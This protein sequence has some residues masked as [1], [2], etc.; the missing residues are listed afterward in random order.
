MLSVAKEKLKTKTIEWQEIDAQELPFA[1]NSIDLVVCC[2]G[3]MFVPD[4]LKAYKEAYRVL[5][6]GGMLLFTSWDKLEENYVSHVYRTIAKKY[7]PDPL[8]ESYS[9]PFS[10]SDATEIE[11]V[12]Q[13]AGFSKILVEKVSKTSVSRTAKKAAEGLTRG[14]AIYNE[15]MSRN[16][17]WVEEIKESLEKELTQKFGA[18]PMKAPMQAVISQAWK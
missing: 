12:L 11:R 10:M 2:F 6:P 17:A 16:P 4:K 13:K 14:G 1:D 3:Y 18:S 15:L 8:P 7:L 5:R 9:L